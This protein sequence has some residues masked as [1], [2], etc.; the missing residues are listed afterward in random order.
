MFVS[1]VFEVEGKLSKTS[2]F[3]S[4]QTRSVWGHETFGFDGA[5]N[6][7]FCM[8]RFPEPQKSLIFEVKNEM[9]KVKK[10]PQCGSTNIK[11]VNPQMWSL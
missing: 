1:L 2:G 7:V 10:C 6:Y 3:W 8:F 5:K 9:I 4:P 11:W